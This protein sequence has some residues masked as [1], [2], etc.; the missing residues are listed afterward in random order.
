MAA[1]WYLRSEKCDADM[2]DKFQHV[3]NWAVANKCTINM[4]KIKALVS[5]RPNARNYLASSELPGIERV[6]CKVIECLA[7]K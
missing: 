7:T 3:L 1:W 6:L 5:H 2:L 4:C